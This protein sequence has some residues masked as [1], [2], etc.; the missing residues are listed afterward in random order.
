MIGLFKNMDCELSQSRADEDNAT[1]HLDKSELYETLS[2]QHYMPPLHS[3]GITREYLLAVH[4]GEAYKV[5]HLELKKFEVALTTKMTKRVGVVNS[6]LLVRKLNILLLARREPELGF[7]EFDPPD[8][9]TYLNLGVALA[10][11]TLHR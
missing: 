2:Q 11:G 3:R 10:S 6:G 8:Q 5:D 1:K 7:D 9:V 4:K